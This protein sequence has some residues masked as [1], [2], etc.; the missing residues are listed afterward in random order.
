MI[1][2]PSGFEKRMAGFL[3]K[4]FECY[5]QALNLEPCRAF[6]V[7]TNKISLDNR[8]VLLYI[9]YVYLCAKTA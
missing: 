5:K 8:A 9:I 1:K 4:E 7:N 6:R 2:L 3:G